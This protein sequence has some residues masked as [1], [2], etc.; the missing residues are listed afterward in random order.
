MKRIATASAATVCFVLLLVAVAGAAWNKTATGNAAG[1]AASLTAPAGTAAALSSSSIR[2]SW[3]APVSGAQLASTY[4]VRRITAPATTVCT[5]AQPETTTSCDDT[6]LTAGT[7][8]NYTIEATLG[9]S[10]TSGQSGQFS[11]TTTTSL[12]FTVAK[13]VGGN[14]TSNTAFNV[15]ITAKNGAATDATVTGTHTLVFSGP[16]ASP[17]GTNPTYPASVTF[18]AGI[19]TASVTLMKA[20]TVALT[21]TEASPARTG[22]SANVTVDPG[23]TTQFA[24]ANPGTRTAGA[25]F[26]V[27]LT[28]QDLRQNTT[29]AYT[30]AKTLVFTGPANAPDGTVPT[31]PT[32]TNNVTFSAGTAG[33]SITLFKAA[34]T[35]LTVTQSAV[36]GTST[37]FTVS[38]GAVA[39]LTFTNCSK[40]GLAAGACG[41]SVA[42]GNNGFMDGFVSLGDLYGNAPTV[43][44]GAAWSVTLTSDN[45]SF[46]VTLSPVTI[47]G[48]AIES[49][50]AFHVKYNGTGTA[51]A[52]ITAHATSGS[53]SAADGTLTVSK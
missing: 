20:E 11:A 36:T 21:V 37:A 33:P 19:G 26:S 35:T 44:P 10:W 1:T 52:T 51:S 4:V 25:A 13:A 18:A 41:T 49:A 12:S 30:G 45:A 9:S 50:T 34:S 46:V 40:N 32:G 48:P 31:Y 29:P 23:A 47:T 27:G 24:V 43:A 53:P 22:T 38:A 8:Y 42:V 16:A 5:I 7:L 3:T 14:A 39:E 28:A 2:V 15:T 17:S 6:G